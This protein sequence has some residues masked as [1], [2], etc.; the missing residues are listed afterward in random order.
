[1]QHGIIKDFIPS[2]CKEKFS[3]RLFVCGAYPEYEYL[4][5]TYGHSEDVV[6]YTGLARFDNLHN[7]E[8]I[9]QI[10]VMPTW[11]NNYFGEFENSDYYKNW[12]GFL[13]DKNLIKTLEENNINLIFYPHYE[14]QKYLKLFD[15]DCKNIIL[16]S[17]EDYDV[18]TLLKESS[19]LITDFSSVYFDFAYMKKP[20][21]YFQFDKDVFFKNHY[22]KGYFDYDTM[23]FGKVCETIGDTVCEVSDIIKN[24]FSMSSYYLQRTESFFP[25]YDKDNCQRIYNE[26]INS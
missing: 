20:V 11:R 21:I 26:I 17:F 7:V 19:V 22:L 14:V 15:T 23:G 25:L 5:K 8:A 12:R 16:A 18:Q 13:Q 10:L 9:R 6:K 24:D 3:T 2:L 4:L 1:L